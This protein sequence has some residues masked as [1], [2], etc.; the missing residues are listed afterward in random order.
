VDADG[1]CFPSLA[2]G[3][4]TSS[5]CSSLCARIPA[6]GEFGESEVDRVTNDGESGKSSLLSRP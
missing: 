6:A 1:R 4:D 3:I 5:L 2:V